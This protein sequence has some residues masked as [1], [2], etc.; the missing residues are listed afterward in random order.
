[1]LSM[2]L[3]TQWIFLIQKELLKF[4]ARY[5]VMKLNINVIS[6]LPYHVLICNYLKHNLNM[7]F[8]V[9]CLYYKLQGGR[10]INEM[11]SVS[12]ELNVF[13]KLHIKKS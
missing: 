11:A 1:M 13:V 9:L 7:R 8:I 4:D 5:T 2:R 12:R 10:N 3:K 6:N